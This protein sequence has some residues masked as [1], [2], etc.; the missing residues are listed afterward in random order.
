M[1]S[2]PSIPVQLHAMMASAF[3]RNELQQFPRIPE[4]C[5]MRI[6][7]SILDAA[8]P[9][10]SHTLY[11]HAKNVAKLIQV[12]IL[13]LQLAKRADEIFKLLLLSCF[14]C[15]WKEALH[16]KR[17]CKHGSFWNSAGR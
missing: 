7:T 14:S 5:A 8:V 12:H 1:F 4:N 13:N 11:K 16:V 15:R 6:R 10:E 9:E 3:Y 2:K 17:L